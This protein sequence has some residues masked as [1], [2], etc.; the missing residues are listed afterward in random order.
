MHSL[1]IPLL[2]VALAGAVTASCVAGA[3]QRRRRQALKEV[4]SEM[5]LEFSAVDM[6]DLPLRF[7]DMSLIGSGH[8]RRADSV[9]SGR[10][11]HR[12]A[13]LLDFCYEVGHGVRRATRNYSVAIVELGSALASTLM[14]HESDIASAPLAARCCDGTVGHWTRLGSEATAH[15]LARIC[16]PLEELS[17]SMQVRRDVLLLCCPA[18][19]NPRAYGRLL[20]GLPD[21]VERLMGHEPVGPAGATSAAE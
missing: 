11:G 9:A 16:A 19:K 13:Y 12:Q 3:R 18:K 14:W 20:A 7:S 17:V 21:V 2:V 1:I 6:H 4:C 8:S 5:R 15:K 10:I